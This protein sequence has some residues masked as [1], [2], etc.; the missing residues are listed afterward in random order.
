MWEVAG[1]FSKQIASII[2]NRA[3]QW[4][5]GTPWPLS[6]G[7]WKSSC[8]ANDRG[9]HSVTPLTCNCSSKI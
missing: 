7:A 3:P 1:P 8:S 6:A 5:L 9:H 2:S 4:A